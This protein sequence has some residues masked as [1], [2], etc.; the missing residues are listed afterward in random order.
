MTYFYWFILQTSIDHPSINDRPSI[1]SFSPVS[2][3]WQYLSR[4]GRWSV[5]IETTVA[6]REAID[7]YKSFISMSRCW[8]N[9][10]I[11]INGLPV[12]GPWDAQRFHIFVQTYAITYA[13]V[14]LVPLLSL[15]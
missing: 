6:P 2:E 15:T 9:E 8:V 12:G 7:L 1:D 14:A 4:T 13:Q 11:Y 5:Q 10:A 3:Q